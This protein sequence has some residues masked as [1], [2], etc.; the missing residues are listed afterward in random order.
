MIYP[1]FCPSDVSGGCLPALYQE[2]RKCQDNFLPYY[3]VTDNDLVEVA[4]KF[5]KIKYGIL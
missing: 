1:F 5:P 2:T 4:R 3:T